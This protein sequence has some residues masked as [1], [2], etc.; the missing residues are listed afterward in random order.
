MHLATSILVLVALLTLAIVRASH[1]RAKSP[2]PPGPT[3]DP[4]IGHLRS[5]P[6][7]N[8]AETFHRWSKIYGELIYLK[9]FSRDM[10]VIGSFE[11]AQD[12]LENR[13]ANYS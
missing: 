7:E 3:A 4:F 8:Q 5:I 1:K 9:V 10:V 2:L 13:S 6:R 12:L 11:V